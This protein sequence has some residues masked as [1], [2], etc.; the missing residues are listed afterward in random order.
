MLALVYGDRCSL[1]APYALLT[2]KELCQTG[3]FVQ[4]SWICIV[5]GPGGPQNGCMPSKRISSKRGIGHTEQQ[6][7]RSTCG[8]KPQYVQFG[9]LTTTRGFEDRTLGTCASVRSMCARLA[10]G[11]EDEYPVPASRCVRSLPQRCRRS[12]G[13]VQTSQAP[14]GRCVRLPARAPMVGAAPMR[15]AARWRALARPTGDEHTT[16][17]WVLEFAEAEQPSRL[18]LRA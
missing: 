13:V 16:L 15:V 1:R 14:R 5:E 9:L 11:L 6:V 3:L 10:R 7:Y 2:L 18:P 17:G 12:S 8:R 4:A